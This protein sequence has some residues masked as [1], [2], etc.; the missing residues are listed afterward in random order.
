LY[1]ANYTQIITHKLH[2]L[3]TPK[4]WNKAKK[5]LSD[6]DEVLAKIISSYKGEALQLKGDAFHTLARAI[7][8]QQVSVK[9]ADSIWARYADL[10]GACPQKT[11][12]LEHDI[13]RGAGLSNQKVNYLKNIAEFI[14]NTPITSPLIGGTEG[15][16]FSDEEVIKQLCTIKGVGRWTAEM[17]LIFHLGRQN[18]LP[19]ADL[20]LLKAIEKHYET[21]R[22][23]AEKIA[24]IWQPYRSV[25][26]WY[27][28]RSLDPVAVEY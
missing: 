21:P 28:W 27:L 13:L 9:A 4:Y 2:K 10:S 15:G 7:V 8:G 18:V 6:K 11:L 20:G 19:L 3:M 26:T 22:E 16:E 17:F 23:E 1:F 12:E 5:H 14:C 24:E 25:A